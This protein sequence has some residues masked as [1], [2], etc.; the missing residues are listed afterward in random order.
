VD[1][2]LDKLVDDV[3]ARS[4]SFSILYIWGYIGLMGKE[5]DRKRI[6][7]ASATTTAEGARGST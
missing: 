3:V 4:L 1:N 2:Y 7:R 6:K 5:K